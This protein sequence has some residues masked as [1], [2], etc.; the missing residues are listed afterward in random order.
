[1]RELVARIPW[2]R[3]AWLTLAATTLLLLTTCSPRVTTIEQVE[4]LGALRVATINSPTTYYEGPTGPTGFEYELA[5]GL[6]QYLGVELELVIVDSPAAALQAVQ[7]GRAQIAAAGI[8]VTP[9]RSQALRFSRPVLTVV[10][11]LIYRQGSP[12]PSTPAD[13]KEGLVVA[14]Q[15]AAV[16]HLAKLKEQAPELSWTETADAETEEL[17]LQVANGEIAYTVAPSDVVAINQR[18]YP[19]LRVAFDVAERQDVAWAFP[20]GSDNSLYNLAQHYLS[21]K[22][23]ADLARLRDRYFGH[24]EQVD[25]LG[26]V[27]LATHVTTRLPKYRTMF[28]RAGKKFGMDWRLIAAIGYQESHW[29]PAAVSPTGVRGIMQLTS[30]TA[31]FL[32]VA[33]REDP[34]QSINGGARYIR[35]LIDLI[36]P[37][38]PDPDR[39]W[40]ALAAYNMGYGHLIDVRELARQRGGDSTRWVDVRNALPLLTQAR[41]YQKTRH[42][43]ARGHEARTY[44]GNV[45]TYYDMLVY[46]FG[47]PPQAPVPIETPPEHAPPQEDPLNIRTPVL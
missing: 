4:E 24:V 2:W 44:V 25:Y 31:K 29:D 40:L 36:P 18:Y 8:S 39:T 15:S 1:M 16:E 38:V 34:A 7:S 46:L 17:L 19:Q 45:R 5:L 28:E 27:A 32:N 11:Q 3:V 33:N 9:L 30:E 37:E 41:W 20:N 13:I 22:S 14:Q 26:A 35:R 10:P 42:G 23:E 47:D 12:R 43:Y 6:A 21:G